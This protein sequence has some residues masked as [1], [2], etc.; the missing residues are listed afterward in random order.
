MHI[1]HTAFEGCS[2]LTSVVIPDSVEHIGNFAFEGC[3]SLISIVIGNRVTSIDE[4]AFLGCSSLTSIVIPDSVRWIEKEAF[5][6]CSSL[7]SIII[8]NRVTRIEQAVF[9]G[10]SSLTSVV[11]PD[12]VT[13]I[14]DAAFA[15]CSSLTSI[16]IPDSVISIEDSAFEGCKSLNEQSIVKEVVINQLC[17]R[18]LLHNQLAMV[19]GYSGDPETIDIPSE[20]NMDGIIYRVTSLGD[21]A[22]ADCSSLTSVVIPESVTYI[23]FLVFVDSYSLTSFTFQGTIAQWKQVDIHESNWD[24]GFPFTVIHCTDGDVK[25][26]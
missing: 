2:S 8:G 20:I 16:V 19:A 7:T 5:R 12:S 3:S 4:N 11:I 9:E 23:G 25:I 18:L 17:F 15:G 22:L 10:C 21:N 14:E 6:N 24:E 1:V 26:G 13:S